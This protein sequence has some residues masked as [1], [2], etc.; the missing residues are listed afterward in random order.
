M[1]LRKIQIVLALLVT[2]FV[3]AQ[4]INVQPYLQDA[5][6][7]SIFI[8]WESNFSSES[9]VEW[10]LSDT[11]GNITEGT[12]FNSL[13]D[14]MIHEVKLDGLERFTKYYY[15]VRT[16]DAIS[17]IFHFKTPPFASDNKSFRIAAMS[18]M[19]RNANN[20]DQYEEIIQDGIIDYLK[21]EFGGDIEDNLAFVMIPGDLV[22]NGNDYNRWGNEFF[23]PSHGLINNGTN[24]PN[25]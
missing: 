9:I 11:L 3:S 23:K 22:R 6:P 15:R 8:M 5:T 20:P 4:I 17:D 19:Q 12:S 7:N 2:Q 21:D 24:C 14:A 25:V 16:G 1:E 18:D 13:G 10:G